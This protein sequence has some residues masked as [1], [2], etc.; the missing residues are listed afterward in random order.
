M[1]KSILL[2]VAVVVL[3]S[4]GTALAASVN[5]FFDRATPG[6][7]DNVLNLNGTVEVEDT[8]IAALATFVE[9]TESSDRFDVQITW[10]DGNGTAIAHAY[11]S[12]CYG[13]EASTGV[14]YLT[15]DGTS[16]FAAITN[17]AVSSITSGETAY[18][19]S[20]AAGL[21]GVRVTQTSA[22]APTQY[23]CCLNAYGVPQC[24]AALDWS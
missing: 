17:G 6:T 20:T 16:A 13:S 9:G 4:A 7:K 21:L 19:T 22:T 2:A 12:Y 23:L 3:A 8:R 15:T 14:G 24:S 5:N 11:S 10:T 1:K 18:G